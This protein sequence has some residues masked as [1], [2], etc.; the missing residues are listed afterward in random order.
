MRPFLPLVAL[1][2]AV[3]ATA[4]TISCVERDT[5][6]P[7]Y[8][9]GG[10][11]DV[12]GRVMICTHKPTG[13]TFFRKAGGGVPDRAPWETTAAPATPATP[14]RAT[15][16]TAPA[17][18]REAAGVGS[19]RV[20]TALAPHLGCRGKGEGLRAAARQ[21][22]QH[23][24]G[25]AWMPRPSGDRVHVLNPAGIRFLG[26]QID[27]LVHS[28]HE[29]EADEDVSGDFIS[30]DASFDN[31]H[32]A[33]PMPIEAV[34]G[35]VTRQ[36]GKPCTLSRG[37]SRSCVVFPGPNTARMLTVHEIAPQRT[38]VTCQWAEYLD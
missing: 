35:A 10:A 2:A 38:R 21:L 29:T 6:A 1:L 32:F 30:Y 8:A 22:G 18:Q 5:S 27:A 9:A 33:I 15:G 12:S 16:R 7:S 26:W 25:I 34:A 36:F 14:P 4:Q 19:G 31:L 28:Q 24:G 13:R 11:R 17:G 20:A 3:P 37:S 23:P